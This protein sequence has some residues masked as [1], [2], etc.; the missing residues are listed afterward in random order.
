MM[1]R[2]A[3]PCHHLSRFIA[4]LSLLLTGVALA[5]AWPQSGTRDDTDTVTLTDCRARIEIHA[6]SIDFDCLRRIYTLPIH[7]WPAPEIDPGTPWQELA[8]LPQRAPE[9]ADNPGTPG[10]IALGKRLF[11]DPRLSRS[12]QIACANCHD[13][14]LGWGD[15][16][17]VSFGHDRQPGR[18]NAISVAMS[19]YS[20]PLFWDGRAQTLEEQALHPIQDN[21]E[22]AF[23]LPEV[24]QRLNQDT[25]YRQ[26]FTNV[27]DT[28]EITAREISYAL[29]AFQ[30]S[31]NPRFNRFDRFLEGRRDLLNDQQLWGL[32]VFRTRARCMNCHSGPA[33]TNNRFHNLG[34][35]FHGRARQDLGRYEITGDPT[36]SGKFRTPSLRNVGKTGPY[37]H[38]G[39][40]A[41]LRGVINMYN[42]GMPRPAPR[43]EQINDSSFPQPDPL[44]KPLALH[45]SEIQ[46]IVEFL[47]TL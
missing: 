17:S 21:T 35:H 29:A 32:H 25:V 19:A 18:R 30:R 5:A 23:T 24:E 31:L 38:N 2:S 6:A 4:T 7:D 1:K 20:S 37:M 41:E 28:T 34:L 33:L 11:N 9:P 13:R 39:A 8:A 26:Q 46:A 22:M 16:R 43:H 27:F 42:A 47:H 15:G 45:R 10:K 3:Q 14:Q 40:F 44:L 12:G 36:D